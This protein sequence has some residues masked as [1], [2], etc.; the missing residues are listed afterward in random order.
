MIL[1]YNVYIA[2]EPRIPGIFFRGLYNNS[3]QL[4]VFKYSL[5]SVANIYNWSKII[6]NVELDDYFNDKKDELFNYIKLLFTNKN[7]ILNNKRCGYQSDWQKL[8]E[9]L[10]DDLIFF[11]CNP[12]QLITHN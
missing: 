1:L 9:E 2:K 3:S 8:Y 6:I 12:T 10:N 7:L 11:C 4:D 5:C